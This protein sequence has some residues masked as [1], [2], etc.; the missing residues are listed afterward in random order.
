MGSPSRG[1][2][3]STTTAKPPKE[4]QPYIRP[5]MERAHKL[6]RQPYR[7]YGGERVA[8]LNP[9]HY[10]GTGMAA[11]RALEGDPAFDAGHQMLTGA[12]S[13]NYFNDPAYKNMFDTSAGMVQAKTGE[14]FGSE[15]MFNSGVRQQATRDL[16]DL[17]TKMAYQE[18]G[19][20]PQYA[21]LALQY[22][23]QPYE[24][25]ERLLAAGDVHRGFD[26]ARINDQ[27]AR[28]EEKRMHPYQQLDTL[29]NALRMGMGGGG[30]T[31][32]TSPGLYQQSRTAGMLGGGLAGYGVGQQMGH[33]LA[34]AA[35][36]GLAG[37]YV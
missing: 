31:I 17:A 24:D 5:F 29:G 2:D 3:T 21:N 25:A 35:L 4:V 28:F 9:L 33:P 12:L 27:I 30:T 8:G 1:T 6:S 18:R 16:N 37:M 13:G 7:G 34:G 19:M 23:R 15:G 26:Q 10:A 32:A 11:Q 14:M 20:M 36:G 22:G